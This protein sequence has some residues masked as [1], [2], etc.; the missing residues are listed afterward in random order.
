VRTVRCGYDLFGEVAFLLTEGQ[1]SAH[2]SVPTLDRHIALVRSWLVQSAIDVVELPPTPPGCDLLATLTHDIDFLGIRRHTRDRTLLGFLYRASIGSLRDVFQGRRTVLE[3]LRNWLALVSLPL[4]Y[5][6]VVED[7]WLPF[8]RY[9]EADAPG[10]ST[11]FVVP[12]RDRPGMGPDDQVEA[13]RAVPYAASEI[14]GELRHLADHGHE[15]A[16]HGIDAWRD[17]DLGR[18]ELA[19]IRDATGS[20]DAGVRMHW[21]YFD[22]G[23]FSALEEAG[24]SYDATFGYNDTIGFRAGTAQVFAPLGAKRLLELPLQVQDTALLYPTRMHLRPAEALA[25]CGD[26]IAEVAEHGGVATISWHERSL[27]PERL[28]GRVYAGVLGL[29]RARNADVRTAGEVVA[30]FRARRDI[31]L[32][33]AHL[34]IDALT[35][36]APATGDPTA[37]RVRIHR[38]GGYTDHAVAA[39]D[40]RAAFHHVEWVAS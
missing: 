12:F 17:S 39:A 16:V 26:L 23:S 32:E 31:R 20:S 37:L 15:I 27:S 2:A 4:V 1:P 25:A 34:D 24:F 8:R 3:L 6:G 35:P 29:L 28:W 40:V 9:V 38:A 36:A 18:A 22:A 30:W 11:F 10:R 7:F 21:L 5:A 33:G 14:A 13:A 19:V